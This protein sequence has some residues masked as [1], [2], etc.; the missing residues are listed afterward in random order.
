MLLYFEYVIISCICVFVMNKI[1]V[2]SGPSGVGK[3]TIAS[4]ILKERADIKHVVSCTTRKIRPNEEDGVHY[5]FLTEDEFDKKKQ[6][7]DFIETVEMFGNK[8]G[9]AKSGIKMALEDG[10]VISVISWHGFVKIK[11]LFG[12]CA[13]G[14][15]IMPP[16]ID[17]LTKRI[18]SRN[19]E[20][21]ENLAKRLSLVTEDIAHNDLYE[22]II[23][24]DKLDVAINDLL[25]I[26]E[27]E[28][29]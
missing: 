3:S 12:D 19:T 25:H 6:M 23:V 4:A 21:K 15:F 29:I 13:V 14:I 27:N 17:E 20:S 28:C 1:F 24:N 8:Y 10:H 11:E 7:G 16:S 5:N 22:Y 2:I 9:T 26:I 18:V